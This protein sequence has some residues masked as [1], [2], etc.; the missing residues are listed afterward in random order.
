MTG[1]R[2][3]SSHQK[4]KRRGS[5]TVSFQD[6]QKQFGH[7]NLSLYTYIRIQ[8]DGTDWLLATSFLRQNIGEIYLVM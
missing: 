8:P 6:L 2:E 1:W 3:H 4:A 5:A 7:G